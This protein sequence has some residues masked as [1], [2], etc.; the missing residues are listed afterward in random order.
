MFASGFTIFL[1]ERLCEPVVVF[2]ADFAHQ[3]II[4]VVGILA[5]STEAFSASGR[6]AL[7]SAT[8]QGIFI[9][10]LLT[11]HTQTVDVQALLEYF[12]NLLAFVTLLALDLRFVCVPIGPINLV[13]RVHIRRLLVAILIKSIP[14]RHLHCQVYVWLLILHILNWLSD[15]MVILVGLVTLELFLLLTNDRQLFHLILFTTEILLYLTLSCTIKI[16]KRQ[17]R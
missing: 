8:L 17:L 13:R 10:A 12:L 3:H 1:N 2:D 5:A 6:L 16:L 7:G 15:S 14:V 9:R 4:T 11:K